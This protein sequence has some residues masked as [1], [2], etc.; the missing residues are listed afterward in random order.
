MEK[1]EQRQ[2]V[3][4][5][6]PLQST[7]KMPARRGGQQR[8]F[9]TRFLDATLAEQLLTGIESE[10]HLF[11]F[12]RFGN[13]DEL[14]FVDRTTCLFRRVSDLGSDSLQVFSDVFHT[15]LYAIYSLATNRILRQN[16]AI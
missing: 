10:P 13:R 1:F 6:V 12:V 8:N 14:D 11:G 3:T 15:E 16:G 9:R 4:D 7:D 2:G 5:L